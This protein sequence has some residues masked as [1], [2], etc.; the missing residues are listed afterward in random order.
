[1]QALPPQRPRPLA[2]SPLVPVRQVHHD[3]DE[4][5]AEVIRP[6]D[7]PALPNP[8]PEPALSALPGL[9]PVRPRSG[10]PDA[11]VFTA[12]CPAC[13]VD[14]EWIEQREDT[15]LHAVVRCSCS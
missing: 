8:R 6:A 10:Q 15:R 14:C 9:P 12:P 7:R 4:H 5:G 2:P 1:M 11:V 3:A 13:G